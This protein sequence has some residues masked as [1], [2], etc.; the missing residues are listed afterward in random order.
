MQDK[1]QIRHL[2][3]ENAWLLEGADVFDHPVDLVQLAAF[4]ADPGHEMIIA[5]VAG[6][7]VGMASGSVLL[8]PDKPPAFLISEVGV[9][10][11]MRLRGIGTALL[12][13]LLQL[14][15]A[16]GCRGI[17]LATEANN[18]AARAL[19]RKLGARETQDVVVCD[20]DGAMDEGV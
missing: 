4:I 13:R 9:S 17:W 1:I 5:V 7:I 14:A 6:K 2:G 18:A 8:H 16:R 3:A 19:Y 10:K 12:R 20:W 11:D 15:R